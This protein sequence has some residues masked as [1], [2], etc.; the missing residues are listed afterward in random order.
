[1]FPLQSYYMAP[2]VMLGR[3]DHTCDIWSAGVMLYILVSS[4]PPFNG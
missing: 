2:E 4:V 3:Y 1:M